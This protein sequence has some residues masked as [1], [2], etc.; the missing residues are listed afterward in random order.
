M[1]TSDASR[2]NANTENTAKTC[3]F[4]HLNHTSKKQTPGLNP[5]RL[6][7]HCMLSANVIKQSVGLNNIN[8]W[9]VMFLTLSL[10]LSNQYSKRGEKVNSTQL[11]LCTLCY[12]C[13]LLLK[14]P[15]VAQENNHSSQV[16]KRQRHLSAGQLKVARVL[17]FQSC[18]GCLCPDVVILG[19]WVT[20]AESQCDLQLRVRNNS[21]WLTSLMEV[22]NECQHS[23]IVFPRSCPVCPSAATETVE[24][25]FLR[26]MSNVCL[27]LWYFKTSCCSS[28]LL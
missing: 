9:N 11:G 10:I 7:R 1:L 13:D 20:G 25:A 12:V 26:D 5:C 16:R 14:H 24:T 2:L 6:S 22:W 23:L 27:A 17:C 4:Q 28:H 21:A 3:L 15:S 19:V 18:W 8:L